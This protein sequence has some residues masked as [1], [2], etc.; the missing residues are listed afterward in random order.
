MSAKSRREDNNGQ[1]NVKL[2][3]NITQ[4]RNGCSNPWLRHSLF[5]PRLDKGQ[6]TLVEFPGGKAGSYT[7]PN[8]V[9]NIGGGAFWGCPLRKST[10]SRT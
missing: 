2:D 1:Q 3:G 6:T 5:H 4:T 8:T 7:S 9:T 10:S